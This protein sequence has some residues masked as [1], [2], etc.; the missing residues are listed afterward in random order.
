MLEEFA[1]LTKWQKDIF[2]DKI[3]SA[4]LE[5][6][7][8]RVAALGL[9]FKGDTDD[10]RESP[11][12]DL[13]R[14]LLKREPRYGIRSGCRVNRA[15]AVLPPSGRMLYAITYTTRQTAQTLY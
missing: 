13:I 14:K 8:Q 5:P 3:Q 6:A 15:K 7:R 1:K 9:A 2:F 4:A 10:I 12:V 11:A